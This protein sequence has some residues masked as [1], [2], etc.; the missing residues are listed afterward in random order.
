MARDCA[1]LTLVRIYSLDNFF[2]GPD[3]IIN[4]FPVRI[5]SEQVL[6]LVEHRPL[7]RYHDPYEYDTEINEFKNAVL[8]DTVYYLPCIASILR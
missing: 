1:L 6:F 8:L 7:T 3:D 5:D 2:S 4:R